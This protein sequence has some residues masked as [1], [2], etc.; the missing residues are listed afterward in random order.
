VRATLPELP[1]Q[2]RERF[3]AQFGLSAYDASVLASSREQADYFEKVVS[4]SRRRQAGRQLGHGR[5]GQPA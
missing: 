3:Q 5:A 1:P 2:K 4:I